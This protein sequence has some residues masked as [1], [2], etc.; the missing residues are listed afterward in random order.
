MR[1]LKVKLISRKGDGKWF[2][3]RHCAVAFEQPEGGY[4]I[5]EKLN[6]GIP[7][8]YRVDE[9]DDRW[10]EH[11]QCDR[12]EGQESRRVY[13]RENLTGYCPYFNNCEMFAW[14]IYIGLP[15]PIQT[16]IGIAMLGFLAKQLS[17]VKRLLAEKV[18]PKLGES[19]AAMKTA[20]AIPPSADPV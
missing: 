3:L 1:S 13:A 7:K 11:W 12:T 18:W 17:K 14:Y 16:I 6:D 9:L 4:L 19:H 8:E 15:L 5:A 20:R 10:I 2:F